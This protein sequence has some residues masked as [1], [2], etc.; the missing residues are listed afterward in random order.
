MA[1]QLVASQL[2]L[3]YIELVQI[4]RRLKFCTSWRILSLIVSARSARFVSVL[5]LRAPVLPT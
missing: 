4:Y 3:N 1:A 2:V 5:L